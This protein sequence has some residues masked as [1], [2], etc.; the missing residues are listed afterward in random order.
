MSN[1]YDKRIYIK[2]SRL[3]DS[4]V[5]Y[6]LITKLSF[7][8]S[9]LLFIFVEFCIKIEILKKKQGRYKSWKN[10]SALFTRIFF[11]TVYVI[12]LAVSSL[13]HFF[14]D[15]RWIAENIRENVVFFSFFSCVLVKFFTFSWIF[16]F[17][18]GFTWNLRQYK[19][20]STQSDYSK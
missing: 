13:T 5:F 6:C 12:S 2:S 9:G 19:I 16:V 17:F 14:V 4:K 18:V 8:K 10:E 7:T 1:F 11:S 20:R 3:K 15:Y